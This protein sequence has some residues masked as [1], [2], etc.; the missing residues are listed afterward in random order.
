MQDIV[1]L[2]VINLRYCGYV[3]VVKVEGGVNENV[4]SPSRQNIELIDQ[5]EVGAN[6][7]NINRFL[8]HSM[9]HS[10]NSLHL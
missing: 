7:L 3:V 4:N 8:N 5:P 2:G 1:T 10:Y 9:L 6:A